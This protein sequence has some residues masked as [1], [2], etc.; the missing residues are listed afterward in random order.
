MS[1][2]LVLRQGALKLERLRP[3]QAPSPKPQ[4]PS[5]KPQAPSPNHHSY[6]IYSQLKEKEKKK[7]KEKFFIEICDRLLKMTS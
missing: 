7:K 3:S 5:P 6:L 1:R 4:A 2:V